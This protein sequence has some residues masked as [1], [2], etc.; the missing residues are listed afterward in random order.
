MLLILK[1]KGAKYSFLISISNTP[2]FFFL[3]LQINFCANFLN[4]GV[5]NASFLFQSII[6]FSF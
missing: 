4:V 1:E 6:F 2:S 3:F 5:T